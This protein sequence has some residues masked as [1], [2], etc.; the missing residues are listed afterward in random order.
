VISGARGERVRVPGTA[1]DITERHRDRQQLAFLASHDPLT[2]L[3]NRRQLGDRLT[4][5][6]AASGGA[7]LLID[8]DNF[9]DINDSRGQAVGD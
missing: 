4:E 2:G 9:K 6:A 3:A 5:S 8:V 1:Q 7:L